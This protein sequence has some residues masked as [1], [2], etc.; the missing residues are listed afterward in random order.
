MEISKAC[1]NAYKRNQRERKKIMTQE[2]KRDYCKP[3]R[4]EVRVYNLEPTF[5]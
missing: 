1:F 5:T 2:K 3:L 4:K